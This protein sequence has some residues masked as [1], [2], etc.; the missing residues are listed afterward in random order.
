MLFVRTLLV[1]RG[2]KYNLNWFKQKDNWLTYMLPD[3]MVLQP[4]TGFWRADMWPFFLV[5]KENFTYSSWNF[6]FL[7][8][9]R[10]SDG[11][12]RAFIPEYPGCL[13]PSYESFQ[14]E[15][16]DGSGRKIFLASFCGRK[17]TILPCYIKGLV[18]LKSVKLIRHGL[19]GTKMWYFSPAPAFKKN[20]IIRILKDVL[21]L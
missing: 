6:P 5:T 20:D 8:S 12:S 19:Q 15:K 1:A 21:V 9:A 7:D 2:Q 17:R 4:R 11:F 10:S 3:L 18:G 14:P 16:T 13:S